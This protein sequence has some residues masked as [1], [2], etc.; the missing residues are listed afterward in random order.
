MAILKRQNEELFYQ[1]SV[2]KNQIKKI[3]SN[4]IILEEKLKSIISEKLR[5]RSSSVGNN[6][7]FSDTNSKT[8]NM[9][10][11][12][13]IN[14]FNAFSPS[15]NTNSKSTN[16]NSNETN[17]NPYY[18][19][20]QKYNKDMNQKIKQM[21][22]DFIN[23]LKEMNKI[24][25]DYDIELNKIND[26]IKADIITNFNNMNILNDYDRIGDLYKIFLESSDKIL[27]KIVKLIENNEKK[28]IRNFSNYKYESPFINRNDNKKDNKEDNA[29]DKIEE[30]GRNK[31]ILVNKK[32]L[33]NKK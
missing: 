7:I 13:N 3:D 17:K 29:M 10:T 33:S 30:K 26:I 15:S 1:I 11:N 8:I 9:N 19:S 6:K 5:N 12:I 4:N 18:L 14:N 27:I 25:V 28:Q 2:Y 23:L 22:L 31:I 16:N 21:N 24:L 32:N 20:Y